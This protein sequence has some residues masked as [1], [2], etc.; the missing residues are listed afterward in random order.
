M[1]LMER[2]RSGVGMGGAAV[3]VA[4][5]VMGGVVAGYGEELPQ[6]LDLSA[7]VAWTTVI[8][9]PMS[10]SE[11]PWAIDGTTKRVEEDGEVF[12]RGSEMTII[13]F[14]DREVR[15]FLLHLR[16]RFGGAVVALTYRDDPD[17][18]LQ[19]IAATKPPAFASVSPSAT[20]VPIAETDLSPN[21][22]DGDWHELVVVQLLDG[23]FGLYLDGRRVLYGDAGGAQAA[24]AIR[25]Y[26]N[27]R[28]GGTL[29][30]Q[31]VLLMTGDDVGSAV[32]PV[33]DGPQLLS[34]EELGTA[35][36][37]DR[38]LRVV[39]YN[40]L[41]GG[42]GELDSTEVLPAIE[43]GAL[44]DEDYA[45]RLAGIVDLLHYVN[46]DVI[47]FQE[48]MHWQL[49]DNRI[50]EE[51]AQALGMD[52][53][54]GPQVEW[55]ESHLSLGVFSRYEIVDSTVLAQ[56]WDGVVPP[57]RVEIALP[58]GSRLDV[59]NLH[60]AP[61]GSDT[62]RLA[63][64]LPP[65]ADGHTIVL[66]DFNALPINVSLGL[67]DAGAWR[68]IAGHLVDLIYVSESLVS[69]AT[70]PLDLL[71]NV[72]DVAIPSI[73]ALRETDRNRLSDHLPQ[74]MEIDLDSL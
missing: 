17:E 25:L 63:D 24:T 54:L 39:T 51:I 73:C 38:T 46:A 23:G 53:V 44:W 67:I 31:S 55:G 32:V 56:A 40:I 70:E 66:G 10:G 19:V 2:V 12:H 59:I 9:Q 3:A 13:K 68:H 16:V 48:L 58:D 74:V 49:A 6:V 22:D 28:N 36:S 57:L 47:A 42:I 37:D 27:T 15:S 29:D 21:L 72:W 4:I 18:T 69:H 61:D 52:Y 7:F 34:L 20:G 65:Y 41:H 33:D 26:I 8:D 11:N 50:A 1:R 35:E 30:I 71:E 45:Q 64:V 14:A 60:A 5:L 43:S 62:R